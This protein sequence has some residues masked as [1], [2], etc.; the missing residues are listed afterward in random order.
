MADETYQEYKA[1]RIA[2]V[3]ADLPPVV[4][5][6]EPPPAVEGLAP[7]LHPAPSAD[8]GDDEAETADTPEVSAR[9][10]KLENRFK[11]LTDRL[12]GK[13]REI[14]ELRG[15]LSAVVQMVRPH[16]AP[17]TPPEPLPSGKPTREAYRTEDEY[18][19]AVTDWKIEQRLTAL[20]HTQEQAAEA[21]RQQDT[22]RQRSSAYAEREAAAKSRLRDYDEVIQASAVQITQLVTNELLQ[23]TVGPEVVY[24]LA[25]HPDEADR[26]NRLDPVSLGRHLARLEQQVAPPPQTAAPP[27]QTPAPPPIRPI[28]GTGATTP[29]I[30]EADQLPYREYQR[31]RR[32]GRI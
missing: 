20:T 26:L 12:R 15:E 28:A 1:S 27:S 11:R 25:Q 16:V 10:R 19:E 22:V 18:T 17:S 30:R 14:A 6:V 29:P 31:A 9:N 13:D 4:P 8:E 5:A 23:S 21:T 7:E 24:F 3:P 2:S 32:A